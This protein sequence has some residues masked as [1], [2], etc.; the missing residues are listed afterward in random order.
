MLDPQL[1]RQKL[2]ET[3]ALLQN[4]RGFALDVNALSNLEQQRKTVQ[5]DTENLQKE[6]NELAKKIGMAK[7]K[8]EPVDALMA[9]AA[10]IPE[11]LKQLEESLNTLQADI[12]AIAQRVPNIPHKVAMKA[13]MSKCVA[14]ERH[15][16]LI[17]PRKITLTSARVLQC[18]MQK[19]APNWRAHGLPFC[20]A[21]WLAC[22][23]PWRNS[24]WICTP[25]NTAIPS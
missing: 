10:A 17:S 7:G 16:V 19:P 25:C 1:L 23:A 6:R 11:R 12:N 15:A 20:V 14:G 4:R 18:W 9:Q 13:A 5:V 22:T 8:G 21:G 2:A 3:A 24:C